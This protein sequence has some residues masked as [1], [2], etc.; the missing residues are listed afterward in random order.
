MK[1]VNF[2][3]VFVSFIVSIIIIEFVLR[4]TEVKLPLQS[5]GDYSSPL[6]KSY[7]NE[8]LD[9]TIKFRHEYHGNN[10]QNFKLIRKM[11]WHPRIGWNDKD[12]DI[13]C[14]NKLFNEGKINI[15]F[16]GGSAMANYETPNYLTSIE[17]FTFKNDNRFRS[18]NL[19]ESGARL[20][21]EL[22]LFL[23]TI[24]KIKNKIDLVLFF[25]GYNEFNSIRYGGKPDNDFYWTAGVRDRIHKPF[26]YYLDVL[27]ERSIFFR[28]LINFGLNINSSRI[29]PKKIE[30]KKILEAADDYSY[31][32]KIIENLCNIY[33]IKCIFVIQPVFILSENLNSETDLQIKK[34]HNKYFKN[35]K[36]VYQTG[37][38]RIFE[39]NTNIK[40]LIKIF[41]NQSGIY[42]D[43]VH[44]NK[45]GSKIIGENLK[46]IILDELNIN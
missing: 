17:Y 7:T 33:D 22:S 39:T 8:E 20:S 37:Y 25:D 1:L 24:P 38:E 41:D 29:Q 42:F 6:Y 30:N 4:I 12:L 23:E 16:M 5:G 32:K 21:N 2:I 18:I 46:K 45:K 14:V 36:N 11:Q 34:W 31:R 35:D 9:N 40:N 15:I 27:T 19:A 26:K 28:L 10:C 13:K 44:T 3:L 43:Y